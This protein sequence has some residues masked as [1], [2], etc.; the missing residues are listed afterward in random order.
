MSTSD[1]RTETIVFTGAPE[2][3][4]YAHTTTVEVFDH[5]EYGHTK[6]WRKVAIHADPYR[7]AYQC[8]RYGSFL[9]GCPVLDDPRMVPLGTGRNAP[10]NFSR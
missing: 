7:T 4:D 10:T 9:G 3:A 8:D 1:D 5:T 6:T 2:A